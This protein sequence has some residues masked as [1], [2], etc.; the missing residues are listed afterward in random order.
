MTTIRNLRFIAVAAGAALGIAASHPALAAG[1]H[2]GGHGHKQEKAEGGHGHGEHGKG[3]RRSIGHAGDPANADRT[4]EITM[5]DNSFEPEKLTIEEGQ[6]VRFVVTNK[7]EL[8][9]EFNI[10]TA[11]MHS[12]HQAEMMEMMQ[13]GVLGADRIH[14]DKMGEHGMRHDHANSI[15]LEPGESGE[16]V[17]TFDTDAELEFACNVPGHYESGMKGPIRLHQ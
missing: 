15:L 4:V 8:V 6:T 12:S 5:L 1:N 3:E 13:K 16:V 14:H 10:A 2:D 11:A 7:G 9:H 17:W